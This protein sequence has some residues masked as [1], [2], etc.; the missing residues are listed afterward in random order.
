MLITDMENK[1]KLLCLS[2]FKALLQYSP[3]K[4][5]H[6][7]ADFS[8]QLTYRLDHA[9][10]EMM[11]AE[12]AALRRYPVARIEEIVIRGLSNMRKD[13]FEEINLV[14]D[15]SPAKIRELAYFEGQEHI[16]SCLAQKGG[17][18]ILLTHFGFRK[19]LIPALGYAG[20]TVN[21][22]ATHP[23]TLITE[24]ARE[25]V[26]KKMM[27][28]EF[29]FDQASPAN[30]IYVENFLRPIYQSL[31]NNEIVIF[32]IDGP[33]GLKRVKIPFF[34]RHILLP[35]TP[36]A[37]GLKNGIPMLPV[38]VV[39]Q[40]DNRHKIMVEKPLPTQS[41]K[42]KKIPEAEII[43]NFVHILEEYVD[44]YPCHY[45]DYLYRARLNPITRNLHVFQ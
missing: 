23:H 21:Q 31:S 24:K 41:A 5:L 34:H 2:G 40:P 11:Q 42:G 3:L 18:I 8:A 27:E 14:K 37:L 19:L 33:V 25:T 20:Y 43:Q 6:R 4:V 45:V 15:L 26:H 39:R 7:L 12:I 13:T 36:F 1:C 32:T 30:F 17:I 38:F 10:R 28:L 9:K 44:N 29:E 35:P 16:N 22:V